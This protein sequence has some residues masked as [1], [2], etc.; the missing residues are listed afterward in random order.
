M[1]EDAVATVG[2]I[3][4]A[5]VADSAAGLPVGEVD[6]KMIAYAERIIGR[7]DSNN[8]KQLVKSEYEKMLMSP[9]AADANRDGIIT[10]KEYALWM[11]SRRR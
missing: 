11:Q 3:A 2:V 9:V 10:V 1:T 5:T 4:V 6:D 8:D 7:Y